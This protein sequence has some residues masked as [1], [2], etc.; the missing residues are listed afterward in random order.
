MSLME[1]LR[2][3]SAKHLSHTPQHVTEQ[4]SNRDQNCFK[5]FMKMVGHKSVTLKYQNKHILFTIKH[6]RLET[7]RYSK[8]GCKTDLKDMFEYCYNTM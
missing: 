1:K 2:L 8:N 7:K 5:L 4:S 6:Y 3:Q